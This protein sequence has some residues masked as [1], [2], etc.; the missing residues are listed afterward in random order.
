MP[1]SDRAARIN[2]GSDRRCRRHAPIQHRDHRDTEITEKKALLARTVSDHRSSHARPVV[3]RLCDLCVSVI[4]VSKPRPPAAPARRDGVRTAQRRAIRTPQPGPQDTGPRESIRSIVAVFPSPR[5]VTSAADQRVHPRLPVRRERHRVGRDAAAKRASRAPSRE[6]RRVRAVRR[7][8]GAHGQESPGRMAARLAHSCLWS[9]RDSITEEGRRATGSRRGLPAGGDRMNRRIRSARRR[10][11]T[12]G[13][14]PVR[15]RHMREQVCGCAAWTG[16]MAAMDAISGI[17]LRAT[18]MPA[19]KVRAIGSA[20]DIRGAAPAAGTGRRPRAMG[21]EGGVRAP[22]PE[23]P[24]PCADASRSPARSSVRSGPPRSG[25]GT[26]PVALRG[27]P[28]FLRGKQ[29][30]NVTARTAG[31]SPEVGPH[32]DR[33]PRRSRSLTG[34]PASTADPIA[35]AAGMGQFG[36]EIT[37]KKAPPATAIARIAR[38][39]TRGR[40]SFCLCDLCVSVISVSKPWPPA[41]PTRQGVVRIVQR[42]AVRTP[43]PGLQD[44]ARH[45]GSGRS[46]PSPHQ[47]GKRPQPAAR[48]RSPANPGGCRCGACRAPETSP[49][50]GTTC[51]SVRHT[52]VPAPARR[53][54]QA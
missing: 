45:K 5:T 48:P 35:G 13:I 52:P 17:A 37:E 12:S 27:P 4:S 42:P 47:H 3:V 19:V 10:T 2:R 51:R 22:V 29:N 32:A 31:S 34:S 8:I 53:G 11:R 44:P 41:A 40:R 33:A 6:K 39:R 9:A 23:A 25:P 28:S 15:G 38:H 54:R 36:T 20:L 30:G 24:N 1:Q 43:P 16:G 14:G 21:D 18:T 46:S 26:T 50:P 49:A 7:E